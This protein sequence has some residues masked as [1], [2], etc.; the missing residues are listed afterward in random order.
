MPKVAVI[1][2]GCGSRDGAEVQESVLILLE[3]D[4]AGAEVQCFAP[5][6]QQE[7]VVS[8][9]DGS[10]STFRERNVLEEAAR[11]ARGDIVPLADARV[12]DFDA[13]ILP[14]GHGVTKNLSNFAYE[15]A[16]CAVDGE[17]ERFILGMHKAGKPIGA[18]CLAALLVAKILGDA[19]VK[20][21]VTVGRDKETAQS[22]RDCG[23]SHADC[24]PDSV[25]ID[26]AN[27]IVTTPAYMYDA[28]TIGRVDAG[29]AKMVAAVLSMIGR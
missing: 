14:G 22:V 5:D 7:H 23:A 8:H 10:V 17:V 24:N 9:L 13:V 19:E 16:N 29:I 2:S 21:T 11:I 1:L 28:T 15:G 20:P 4:K 18:A 27:K 26:A 12:A 3:L 25:T 6:I